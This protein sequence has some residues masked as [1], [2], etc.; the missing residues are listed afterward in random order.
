[1][2]L[3]SRSA[4]ALLFLC[5]F[6]VPAL[7]Q[8]LAVR[9]SPPPAGACFPVT[10]KNLRTSPLKCTSAIMLVID[11][12]TCK[13]VC[14]NGLN[15]NQTLNPCQSFTFKMCCANPPLP[16]KHIVYVRIT[17]SAGTNEEWYFRP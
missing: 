4:I 3:L 9:I 8:N 10:I 7:A 16:P 1:M 14:K 17:H 2:K 11:Q 5:V 13:V 6:A 12:T 15:I